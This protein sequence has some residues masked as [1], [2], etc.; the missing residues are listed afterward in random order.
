[1]T[2]FSPLEQSL[3]SN[4]TH[5]SM[6]M[7][8]C[9]TSSYASTL[10]CIA[11]CTTNWHYC[12]SNSFSRITIVKVLLGIL[13][14]YSRKSKEHTENGY[15]NDLR[16]YS[17]QLATKFLCEF[18]FQ[19]KLWFPTKNVPE[20]SLPLSFHFFDLLPVAIIIKPL[21]CVITLTTLTRNG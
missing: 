9:N 21:I 12:G 16:I 5:Q 1:M 8:W 7:Q 4:Y 14:I 11:S 17:V 18:F 19:Y 15:C 20:C 13:Y 10:N 6:V 3:L 2:T